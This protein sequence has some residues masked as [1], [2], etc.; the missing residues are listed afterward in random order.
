ML[1]REKHLLPGLNNLTCCTI[2]VS[3]IIDCSSRTVEFINFLVI[4]ITRNSIETET[5][6]FEHK[7][8]HQKN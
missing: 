7:K 5:K 3:H 6:E 8:A 1:K 2:N 4:K